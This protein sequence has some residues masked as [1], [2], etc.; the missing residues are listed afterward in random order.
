ME[1]TVKTL[2]AE[3]DRLKAQIN[4]N[5]GN[6]SKPPSQDGFKRIPNSREPSQRKSGGQAGHT[7]SCLK[8][9]EKLDKLIEDGHARQEVVNHG[10]GSGHYVSRYVLDVD[11]VLIV[12]E[13]RYVKGCAPQGA[14][15]IYGEKIKALAT[16]L[17][18]F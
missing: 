16:L 12:T 10:T 3:I 4:K 6:S 8:L 13:H 17:D 18:L 9:P 7:G 1:A 11:V 5:S 2:M 14:A 15:V